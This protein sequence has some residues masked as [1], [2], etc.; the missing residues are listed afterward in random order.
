MGC[1]SVVI[2]ICMSAEWFVVFK[3][4]LVS[5]ESLLR[6]TDV[7]HPNLELEPSPGYVYVTKPGAC[8][9]R[10]EIARLDCRRG[11]VSLF[12][13]LPSRSNRVVAGSGT[14]RMTLQWVLSINPKGPTKL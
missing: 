7:S 2:V 4:R 10:S 9:D 11:S 12:G 13:I 14:S 8:S 1:V 6:S 5:T 3:H